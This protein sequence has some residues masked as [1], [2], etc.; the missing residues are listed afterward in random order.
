MALVFEHKDNICD[1]IVDILQYNQSV[2]KFDFKFYK[3]ESLSKLVTEY[4]TKHDKL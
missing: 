1:R 2:R 3:E 4:Y